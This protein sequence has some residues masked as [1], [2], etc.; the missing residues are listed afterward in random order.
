MSLEE[1]ANED[2]KI[3]FSNVA[4]PPDL[5]YVGDPG[6]DLVEIV[7]TLSASSRF[8]RLG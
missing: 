6:I 3:N 2:M 1:I 4:G 7:P 8:R 5:V